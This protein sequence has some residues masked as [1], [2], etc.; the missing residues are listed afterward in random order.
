MSFFTGLFKKPIKKQLPEGNQQLNDA[1]DL[2][3]SGKYQEAL[4]VF[5]KLL[6]CS[7]ASAAVFKE[8]GN[9]LLSL[10]RMDEAAKAYRKAVEL[11]PQFSAAW[12]NLGNVLRLQGYLK[13]SEEAF[14]RALIIAPQ[15][16]EVHN[17][18][19]NTLRDSGRYHDAAASFKRAVELHP[20]FAMA[21]V[22]YGNAQRLNAQY[23]QAEQSLLRAIKLRPHFTEAYCCLGQLYHS[24]GRIKEAE[25]IYKRALSFNGKNVSLYNDYGKLLEI[26]GRHSEAAEMYRQGLGLSPDNPMLLYS[27]SLNLLLNGKY[28]EGFRLFDNRLDCGTPK[29]IKK[30]EETWGLQH[31]TRWKGEPLDGASLL[32]VTEQGAGDSIMMMRYLSAVKAQCNVANLVVLCEKSLGRLFQTIP[33]IDTVLIKEE[34]TR[35]PSITHFCL[36]MSL[37]TLMEQYPSG[38]SERA[39]YLRVPQAIRTSWSSR[40]AEDPAF[41][42]GLV[43]AG[44]QSFAYD[45]I[46]SIPAEL[47]VPLTKI[48]GVSTYSLQK[49]AG[50]EE[51]IKAGLHNV[52]LISACEDYLDTAGF[53]DVLDLIISVDTSVAHLAGALGKPVWLL[54]RYGSEWR[55]FLEREDSEWYPSMKIFRQQYFGDWKGTILKVQEELTNLL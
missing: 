11:N 35:L 33:Q 37:P 48:S 38:E 29:T 28:H 54:N 39:A 13:D 30:I 47:F 12:N 2:H 20:D 34:T 16:P 6:A 27:L 15:D 5:E 32:V 41:K 26:S 25:A 31:I 36:I 51:A 17:N 22:N 43:W 45:A 8:Y 53:I 1:V 4:T 23:D 7:T 21:W 40:I 49:G 42:V 3:R 44:N 9:T 52:T 14:L 55:W 10:G 46:R 50:G 19:G 24:V 18:F